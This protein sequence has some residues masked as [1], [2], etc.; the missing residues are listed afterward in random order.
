MTRLRDCN[1]KMLVLQDGVRI[2]APAGELVPVSINFPLYMARQVEVMLTPARRCTG[3]TRCRA[4]STSLPA[5]PA[6]RSGKN[7]R[8]C[9]ARSASFLAL[10]TSR[11][12]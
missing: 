1:T 12:A 10:P 6:A 5:T 9:R 4:S 3:P 7:R 8:C 2:G 11:V